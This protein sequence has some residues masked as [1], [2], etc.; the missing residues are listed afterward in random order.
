MNLDKLINEQLSIFAASGQ[1]EEIIQ[2]QLTSMTKSLVQ[3]AFSSYGD[4]AKQAEAELKKSLKVDFSELGL[5]GYNDVIGKI[6]KAEVDKMVQGAATE[7]I[8]GIVE[9]IT[10]QAPAMITLEDLIEQ[11]IEFKV[12]DEALDED[13]EQLRDGMTLIIKETTGGYYR[14]AMD[15]DGNLDEYRCDLQIAVN[16][17]GE[18]YSLKVNDDD[19]EKDMF[20]GRLFHQFERN[21]FG[22]WSCGT[23]LIEIA[24]HQ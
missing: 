7:R 22:M 6:V 1:P 16:R 23:K 10:A 2:A 4:L 20:V 19:F 15:T 11:F 13:I 5:A 3:S 9:K 21:L 17:Q 12:D 24:E 18:I 8:K 14:I